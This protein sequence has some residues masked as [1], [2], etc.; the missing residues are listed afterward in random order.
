MPEPSAEKSV[1]TSPKEEN[2]AENI[3]TALAS[4]EY[5][6][7]LEQALPATQEQIQSDITRVAGV[8]AATILLAAATES[9][10]TWIASHQASMIM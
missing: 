6:Q 5:L 9:N 7:S 2:G 10:K 1:S 8:I 4:N 3:P